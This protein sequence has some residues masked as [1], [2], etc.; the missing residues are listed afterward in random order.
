MNS[1]IALVNSLR[2]ACNVVYFMQNI[3]QNRHSMFK[4]Y[5][6]PYYK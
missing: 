2:R 5:A 4:K 1:E 3:T 6:F